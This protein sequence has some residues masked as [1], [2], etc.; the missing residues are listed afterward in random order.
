MIYQNPSL[1]S[2]EWGL[3]LPE[4][5]QRWVVVVVVVTVGG[6]GERWW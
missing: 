3:R 1:E 6:G 5:L 4:N 2:F